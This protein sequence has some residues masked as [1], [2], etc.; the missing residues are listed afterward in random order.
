MS[1][2]FWVYRETTPPDFSGVYKL[3]EEEEISELPKKKMKVQNVVLS[4]SDDSEDGVLEEDREATMF[5]K[6]TRILDTMTPEALLL[7]LKHGR[8]EL[9][10]VAG[11]YTL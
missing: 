4:S 6:S 1:Y 11:L 7:T 3:Q 5:K 8:K 9:L 10:V 2:F